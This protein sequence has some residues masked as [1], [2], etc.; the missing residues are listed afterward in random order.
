[1]SPINNVASKTIKPENTKL[2]TPIDST[3]A[4]QLDDLFHFQDQAAQLPHLLKN[5][6]STSNLELFPIFTFR[7]P[8]HYKS[9]VNPTIR[10]HKVLS[11]AINITLYGIPKILL[12]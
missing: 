5:R 12:T 8:L 6:F 9:T 7:R 11:T 4:K 1:M 10:I 3:F 2:S